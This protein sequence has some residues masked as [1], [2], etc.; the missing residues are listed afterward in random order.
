[1]GKPAKPSQSKKSTKGKRK[2]LTPEELRQVSGGD[3]SPKERPKLIKL[4]GR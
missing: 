3:E 1:M 2:A 4:G